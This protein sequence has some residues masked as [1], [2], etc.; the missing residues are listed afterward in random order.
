V[1]RLILAALFSL[2]VTQLI[3]AE[4]WPYWRGPTLD[5]VSTEKGLPAEWGE[6]KN[7]VWTL[8]MPGMGCSTPVVWG[9]R[10][11]LTSEDGEDVVLLC[12]ST[13][14]K[15]L[16]KHKIGTGGRKVRGDEGNSATASSTT[17]GKHVWSFAGSGELCCHTIDGE[18][19]WSVNL[20]KEYGKFRT[21]FG[22]HSSPLHHGNRIYMQVLHRNGQFVF[23][24]DAA[25]GK[26]VWKIDRAGEGVPGTESPDGYASIQLKQGSNPYLVVH[27][28]D[29]TTGHRLED[30]SE[31]WRVVDENQQE[32]RDWR[33]ISSPAV[34]QD[35]IVIPTCKNGVTVAVRTDIEG[36]VAA[37]GKGELWRLKVTTDVPSPLIHD[38]LVY[39]CRGEGQ[40][41]CIEAK[42]GKVLYDERGYNSRHRASPVYADGKIYLTARNGTFSVIDA[43]PTYKLLSRH[44][45]PD[46]FAASPAISNG[47]I[48]L[49]G[50]KTLYAIGNK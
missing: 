6:G 31:I 12:V 33:F 22:M 43:G 46:D 36:K 28:N 42:T 40:I 7:V 49:R 15:L 17:D 38:G 32:R 5:G 48:Y 50:F 25:T 18:P 8:P 30:G 4:N 2:S 21:N 26:V 29:A 14:G 1:K 23:A 11:F 19:V 35:L 44:K 24:F 39:L 3:L 27:G 47:R 16:W 34:S 41:M 20:Q 13:D 9:E 10:M 37:G 45:L